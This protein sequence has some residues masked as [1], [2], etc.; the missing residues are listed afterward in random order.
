M[1][2]ADTA[3]AELIRDNPLRA[4]ELERLGIAVRGERTLREACALHRVD[5]DTARRALVDADRAAAGD[6]AAVLALIGRVIEHDHPDLRALLERVHPLAERVAAAHAAQHRE[7]ERV[8]VL[9]RALRR[10]FAA[11]FAREE[12]ELFPAIRRLVGEAD[13]GT[14][15]ADLAVPVDRLRHEHRGVRDHFTD[16]RQATGDY[17]AP[18]DA[19]APFRELYALLARLESDLRAHERFEEEILFPRAVALAAE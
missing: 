7:L 3:L 8:L 16:L 10:E 4:R 19:D 9:V 1:S 11:H 15:R 14:T 2:V 6:G 13:T 18:S 17:V 12:R 5:L